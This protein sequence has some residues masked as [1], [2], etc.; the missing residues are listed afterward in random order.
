MNFVRNH[1]ADLEPLFRRN[2]TKDISEAR[3]LMSWVHPEALMWF[4][5]TLRVDDVLAAKPKLTG[6]G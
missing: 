3:R 6:F 5:D 2:F 1:A 4:N